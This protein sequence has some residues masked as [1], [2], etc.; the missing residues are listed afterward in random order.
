MG[1][2]GS[3]EYVEHVDCTY[4]Y[5]YIYIDYTG[6]ITKYRLYRL[7]FFLGLCLSLY[8]LVYLLISDNNSSTNHN[9]NRNN[10]P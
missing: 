6:P 2:V 1:D 9:D 10:A 3:T 5:M 4:K 8:I 7:S